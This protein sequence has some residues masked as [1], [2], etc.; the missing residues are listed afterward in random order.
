MTVHYLSAGIELHTGDALQVLQELPTASVDCVVTSPPY[1]GLR[2]YQVS[3][4]YGHEPTIEDYVNTLR[5]VFG[6]VRRVL[7]PEGTCWLN[8]GDSYGGSWG[9]YVA[10]G[11][12]APTARDAS[13]HHHGRHRPPQ[14]RHRP[15]NLIG[16]PWRVA[17]ALQSD[18]WLLRNAIVWHKPNGVPASVRDRLTCRYETIFLLARSPHHVFDYDALAPGQR[19]D[20]WRLSARPYRRGHVA[21]GPIEIPLRAITVGCRP[22][23]VVLDPFSGTATT[24]LAA[25]RLGRFYIGIDLNPG[26]HDLA[27]AELTGA[28]RR[29]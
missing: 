1:W 26:F 28:G 10:L 4:Q 12:T 18:G 15:K 27:V 8:L 6:E 14:S 3:G 9:N 17:V 23:G 11:S 13:R 22:S 19:G 29:R 2:D 25:R 21:V 7:D 16:V 20:V 5:R 24:G